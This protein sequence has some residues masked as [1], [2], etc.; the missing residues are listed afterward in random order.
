MRKNP[1]ERRSCQQHQCQTEGMQDGS[2]AVS[3]VPPL[4]AHLNTASYAI[5]VSY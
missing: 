2:D 3:D 4:N 5:W 1:P